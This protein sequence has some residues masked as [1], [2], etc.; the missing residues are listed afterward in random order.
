M[1]ERSPTYSQKVQIPLE[2]PKKVGI[3][4]GPGPLLLDGSGGLGFPAGSPISTVGS[5]PSWPW[6]SYCSYCWG[7]KRVKGEK[8]APLDVSAVS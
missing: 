5:L 3:F 8:G 7:G 4:P 6:S 1:S 2:A